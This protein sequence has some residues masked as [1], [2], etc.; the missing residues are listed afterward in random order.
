MVLCVHLSTLMCPM[1]RKEILRWVKAWLKKKRRVCCVSTALIEAGINVS[2]PVVIRSLADIPSMIQAAGRCNRNCE[3][4]MGTVYLWNLAEER[5]GRLPDIQKGKEISMSLLSNMGNPDELG[6]PEMIKKYFI[7]EE[8]YTRKVEKYPYKEWN[9]DLITML[10]TNSGC[11]IAAKN[12]PE[13][14][15]SRLSKRFRQ[16]FRTAGAVFQVID[17][18]TKSVIVP[19]GWGKELIEKLA[20]QHTLGEEIKYLK[21]AQQYSV[22]LFEHVFERLAK[23]GALNSLGETGAV[24]L[25]EEYYDVWAGVKIMP[26]EMKD[27]IM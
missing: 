14:R 21:E 16:S 23:E 3:A 17:Q 25:K 11:I 1:H 15:S 10:S 7:K 20:G 24:V 26:Q 27:L 18:K 2:F 22:N 19:Y 12:K 13:D 5:L 4:D 6:D 9:S 8:E